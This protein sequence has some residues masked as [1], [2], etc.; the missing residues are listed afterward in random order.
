MDQIVLRLFDLA[1]VFRDDAADVVA[2]A[3]ERQNCNR[4]AHSRNLGKAGSDIMGRLRH[5]IGA[6]WLGD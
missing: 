2:S 5:S 3:A 4:F 6:R 1:L